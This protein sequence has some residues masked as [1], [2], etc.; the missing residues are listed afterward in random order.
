MGE[1]ARDRDRDAVVGFAT[2]A[3]RATGPEGQWIAS[4]T[5]D[6]RGGGALESE[7]LK[8]IQSLLARVVRLLDPDGSYLVEGKDGTKSEPE[9]MRRVAPDSSGDRRAVHA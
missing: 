1:L 4:F 3:A 5:D 8:L 2:F 6:L 7:R 9:W